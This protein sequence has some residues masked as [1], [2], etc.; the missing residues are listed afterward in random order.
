MA[1][2]MGS[3]DRTSADSEEVA[4]FVPRSL[5]RVILRSTA[6]AS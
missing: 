2:Q 3:E 5:L 1:R 4:A 6:S